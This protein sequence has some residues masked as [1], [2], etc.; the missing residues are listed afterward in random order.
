M[1]GKWT[2]VIGGIVLAVALALTSVQTSAQ[3]A[4]PPPLTDIQR[5]TMQNALLRVEA[6]DYKRQ[7]AQG[8]Y[9]RAR[10]EATALYASLQVEGYTLDLQTMTR[11]KTPAPVKAPASPSPPK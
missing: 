3:P 11:V 10:Q 6:A 2:R 7:L 5:L 4:A 8:E 9:E 1:T